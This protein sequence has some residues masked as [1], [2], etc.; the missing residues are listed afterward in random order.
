[1]KGDDSTRRFLR[2]QTPPVMYLLIFLMS[3]RVELDAG[4]FHFHLDKNHFYT[5]VKEKRIHI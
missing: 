1:M 3:T 5:W 2:K 4:A